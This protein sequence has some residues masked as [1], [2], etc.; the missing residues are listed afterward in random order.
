MLILHTTQARSRTLAESYISSHALSRIQGRSSIDSENHD[1][2]NERAML[3]TLEEFYWNS[4]MS[5][6]ERRCRH[7]LREVIKAELRRK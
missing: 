6:R 7:G 5:E 4:V 3:E 1:G 2:E